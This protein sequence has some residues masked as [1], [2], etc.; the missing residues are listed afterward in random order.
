MSL[1]RKHQPQSRGRVAHDILDGLPVSGRGGKLVA[2]DHRE[3]VKV[4]AGTRQQDARHRRADLGEGCLKR[5]HQ[6]L[7]ILSSKRAAGES[8]RFRCGQRR[9]GLLPDAAGFAY[10]RRQRRRGPSAAGFLYAGRQRQCRLRTERIPSF[11]RICAVSKARGPPSGA[12]PHG[13]LR[14]ACGPVPLRQSQKCGR[15]RPDRERW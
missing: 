2:G 11:R 1:N 7:F 15:C 5:V 14:T 9:V 4:G 3:T 10:T 13:A 12:R 8:C 6:V